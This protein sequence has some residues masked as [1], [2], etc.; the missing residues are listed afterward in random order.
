MVGGWRWRGGTR[1][2][3]VIGGSGGGGGGSGGGIRGGGE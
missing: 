2:W 1:G 3:E